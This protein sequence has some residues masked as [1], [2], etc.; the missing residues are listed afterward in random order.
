MKIIKLIISF[1]ALMICGFMISYADMKFNNEYGKLLETFNDTQASFK[2]YN[3]KANGEINYNVSKDDMVDICIDIINDLGVEESNIKWDEKWNNNQKQIFAQIRHDEENIS[4]IGIKKNNGESYIMVDILE[5]KLYK[6]IVDIYTIIRN[7]LNKHADNVYINT[8]IC[9][10]YT[11]KLQNDKYDDILQKILYNMSA[12][13][14]DRVEEDNFI[15]ITAY[16]NILKE[17]NL[18]YL[19]DKINLNIGMR[20]SE[21]DDKTL[22]Y[23]ATPIIKLDY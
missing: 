16:S 7:S 4:I 18:G 14:I 8:C 10:E 2:F 20:Y 3:I 1:L 17:N 22:I 15:S 19:G 5:N 21:N 6:D 13:E 12:K 9:G 11:K 23:I